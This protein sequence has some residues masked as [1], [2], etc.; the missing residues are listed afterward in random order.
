MMPAGDGL[1]WRGAEK[2]SLPTVGI[3]ADIIETN[4]SA[5]AQS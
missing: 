3:E 4:I 2:G 5:I 1:S